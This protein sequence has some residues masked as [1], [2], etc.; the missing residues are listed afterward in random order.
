[1]Q[2]LLQKE[3][4][5]KVIGGYKARDGSL[6]PRGDRFGQRRRGFILAW[7]GFIGVVSRRR[8]CIVDMTQL[9]CGAGQNTAIGGVAFWCVVNAA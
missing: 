3:Y 2:D 1:L 4:T 6:P 8:D 5:C 9:I 7:R